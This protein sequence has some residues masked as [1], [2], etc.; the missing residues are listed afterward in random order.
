MRPSQV[1]THLY[2]TYQHVMRYEINLG[3][4]EACEP[5]SLDGH[6]ELDP[7]TSLN[8]L[9]PAVV[10]ETESRSGKVKERVMFYRR[11]YL[12]SRNQTTNETRKRTNSQKTMHPFTLHKGL[13]CLITFHVMG[14]SSVSV[15]GPIS[16]PCMDKLQING[17]IRIRIW[18]DIQISDDE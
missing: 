11:K 18:W 3:M 12:S 4:P 5:T 7:A 15:I 13:I 14:T 9:L 1:Q 2:A 17:I 16:H 10:K 8:T 6:M